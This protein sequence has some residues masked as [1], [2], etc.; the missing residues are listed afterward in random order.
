MDCVCSSGSAI[1][2]QAINECRLC[3]IGGLYAEAGGVDVGPSVLT[4]D[5]D[6]DQDCTEVTTTEQ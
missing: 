1:F 6:D 4:K 2:P 5:G 3:G